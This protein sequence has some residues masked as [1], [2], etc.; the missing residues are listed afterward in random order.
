MI[1]SN[2]VNISLPFG[3][4]ISWEIMWPL[5]EHKKGDWYNAELSASDLHGGTTQFFILFYFLF[6]VNIIILLLIIIFLFIS[7]VHLAR[8]LLLLP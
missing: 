4:V 1:C 6:R 8:F 3:A 7:F 5:I 2:M